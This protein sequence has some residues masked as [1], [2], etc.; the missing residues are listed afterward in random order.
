[1][2]FEYR[3]PI[4]PTVA[5]RSSFMRPCLLAVALTL[6][7]GMTPSSALAACNG[8]ANVAGYW[9]IAP[10]QEARIPAS[11]QT[12]EVS[13]NGTRFF[14]ADRS[15]NNGHYM[16][17]EQN[18]DPNNCGMYGVIRANDGSCAMSV[19]L[20]PQPGGTELQLQVFADKDGRPCRDL[21][22]TRPP[23]YIVFHSGSSNEYCPQNI[24][25][26]WSGSGSV[27]RL[28]ISQVGCRFYATNALL[29]G[30]GYQY[31]KDPNNRSLYG[32]LSSSNPTDCSMAVVID[33]TAPNQ[34]RVNVFGGTNA[35]AC[36]DLPVGTDL[37]YTTGGGPPTPPR[38]T[39]P[40]ATCRPAMVVIVKS[41]TGP[42]YPINV[43]VSVTNAQ[44]AVTKSHLL[45]QADIGAV[46]RSIQSTAAEAGLSAAMVG[47][48]AVRICGAKNAVTVTGAVIDKRDEN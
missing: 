44:S 18:Q 39:P 30:D 9:V 27:P 8:V 32:E 23:N 1:M 11:M 21:P 35:N 24:R 37:H 40:P 48:D 10:G 13:Q 20:H 2:K 33:R 15:A 25:G 46:A 7:T 16:F 29:A 6:T 26:S 31:L 34:L 12:W 45:G 43:S 47:G 22:T 42:Q 41:G 5:G 28:N 19:V 14:S 3:W 17:G 4:F 38:P 36:Q